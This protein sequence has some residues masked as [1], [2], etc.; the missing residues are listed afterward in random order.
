[1]RLS[2][3][4][5][6][7][8]E[9][10]NVERLH[11]RVVAVMKQIGAEFELIFVD[12]GSTDDSAS[13]I[14]QLN[15]GDSRVKLLSL[16]RNFGHQIAL[17]A[18]MDHAEGDAVIC[19]DAD[20]QHP[21]EVLAQLVAKWKEGNDIV[22]TI[23]EST[24]DEATLM[25]RVTSAF[26]YRL[27]KFFGHID[28]P[29]NAA[30]FRLLD[31]RV[32]LAFRSIRER[33]RFL[34]GL[35][36]WVGYRSAAIHFSAAKRTVG[37]TKYSFRKMLS[38]AV[39]GIVSFSTT[40]LY[41]SIYAGFLIATLGFVYSIWVVYQ[42]VIVKSVVQGWASLIILVCLIGGIQLIVLGVIGIYLGR[43]F[44]EVKQRPLYI[45][46]HGLGFHAGPT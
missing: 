31:R 13:R 11:Q 8:N 45:V 21:P 16:S 1:M 38:F 20:L 29:A 26:F 22:Y 44:D 41:L 30:D 25:K 3:V 7:F 5:P 39:D 43:V 40:P 9:G 35:T 17:T 14:A 28:L 10:E 27:F 34:R 32:V 19:M 15:A 18:G 23:R 24:M 46:R 6:V 2:V 4:V 37:S 33:T 42:K 36:S 12:D